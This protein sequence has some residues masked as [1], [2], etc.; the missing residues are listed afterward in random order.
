M[1]LQ[2]LKFFAYLIDFLLSS[3]MSEM[4]SPAGD[5]ISEP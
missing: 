2:N 4:N 5:F 1:T 3:E